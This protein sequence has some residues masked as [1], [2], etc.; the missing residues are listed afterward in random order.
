MLQPWDGGGGEL[1]GRV[2]WSV[3]LSFPP[4]AGRVTAEAGPGLSAGGE[5]WVRG[6]LGPSLQRLI[7][8]PA[9]ALSSRPTSQHGSLSCPD[10]SP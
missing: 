1:A 9:W 7:I 2:P 4:W 8:A 10:T 6:C 3:A 5:G